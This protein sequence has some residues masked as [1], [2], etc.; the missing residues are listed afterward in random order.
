MRLLVSFSPVSGGRISDLEFVF[1]LQ[2]KT[3]R[4]DQLF[5]TLLEKFFREFLELF[6][7]A[8]AERLDFGTLAFLDKELFAD[9]PQGPTREVDVVG[10]LETHEGEPEFVLVHV[11][12]QSR[13]EKDFARRMFEYSALLWLRHRVPIFPVVLYLQGGE[14]LTD[15]EFQ[16]SLFGRELFR[17]RYASVGLA[18]L[19]AEEY[20]RAGPLGAR[21]RR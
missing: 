14:G 21:S 2:G 6:F 15:E 8:V 19:R 16:L 3:V 12:V 20:F 18:R 5:K 10:R 11:E 4:H 1:L 7:P 9:L 13:P 17:F